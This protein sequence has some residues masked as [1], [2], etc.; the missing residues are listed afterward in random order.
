MEHTAESMEDLRAQLTRN[1]N[2]PVLKFK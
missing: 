1:P 2:K